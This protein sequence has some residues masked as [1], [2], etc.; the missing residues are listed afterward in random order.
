LYI[1]EVGSAGDVGVTVSQM[2]TW[3]DHYRFQPENFRHFREAAGSKFRLEFNTESEAAAFASAFG[4]RVLPLV[5]PAQLAP[6]IRMPPTPTRYY[7]HRLHGS[8]SRG[9]S[10]TSSG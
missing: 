1:V 5:E 9:R 3:L 2:R 8:Y 7:R 4:G 10:K 6:L